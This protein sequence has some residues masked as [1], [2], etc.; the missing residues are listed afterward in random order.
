[1]GLYIKMFRRKKPENL[2]K[3]SAR[4]CF[5]CLIFACFCFVSWFLLVLCLML[6][7]TAYF[8]KPWNFFKEQQK[9]MV[10]VWTLTKRDSLAY[11]VTCWSIFTEKECKNK[12]LDELNCRVNTPWSSFQIFW[13]KMK[14]RYPGNMSF[15]V[16]VNI[17][18]LTFMEISKIPLFLPELQSRQTSASKHI[19]ENST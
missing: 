2:Y 7:C 1:M 18:F 16:Q 8:V 9:H 4:C 17:V 6:G 13:R 10:F 11:G 3:H 19:F 5:Y 15:F 14:N 12:Q